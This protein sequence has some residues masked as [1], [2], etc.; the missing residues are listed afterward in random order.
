M[1]A[2][3]VLVGLLAALAL[4]KSSGE[5][6]E[7]VTTEHHCSCQPSL[8]SELCSLKARVERLENDLKA[9]PKVAFSV[10]LRESGSGN[11]GPFQTDTVIQYKKIFANIGNYYNP[12]TGIFTAMVRGV[13][14]LRFAAFNN[15]DMTANTNVVLMKNGE[16]TVS[17][18]DKSGQ[19]A[20]DSA[21]NAV[22]LQLEVG[23]NVFVQLKANTQVY[24]DLGYY[25]SF[26]GFL[27]FP[28]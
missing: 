15:L 8:S 18:W 28:V 2:A 25:N 23:D 13:Y 3:I 12:S 21:S 19:D 6:N 20:N 27:L 1:R 11:I 9:L 24:D 17:I 5:E 7:G 4:G 22:V 14:Y 26:S 16:R 10:A